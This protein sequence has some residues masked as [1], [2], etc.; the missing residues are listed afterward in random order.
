MNIYLHL[1][2]ASCGRYANDTLYAVITSVH[3]HPC[4]F[5]PDNRHLTSAVRASK[6]QRRR[7]NSPPLIGLEAFYLPLNASSP[8]LLSSASKNTVWLPSFAKIFSLSLPRNFM[9]KWRK[10]PDQ[11]LHMRHSQHHFESCDIFPLLYLNPRLS[12]CLAMLITF[13]SAPGQISHHKIL[14]VQ[15]SC[16][17]R[18]I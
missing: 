18:I 9:F 13:L 5:L 7:K 2:S 11:T 6:S 12:K 1:L 10:L 3:N 16:S 8:N 15:R 4:L 17:V 14:N